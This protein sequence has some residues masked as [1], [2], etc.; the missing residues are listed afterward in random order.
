M[1]RVVMKCPVCGELNYKN[2]N[3]DLYKCSVCNSHFFHLDS[4]EV[5]TLKEAQICLSLYQFDK[6]DQLYQNILINTNDEKIIV[7]ALFGRILAYFGVNYIK[8]FNGN[9][10]LTF[11]NYDPRFKSIKET[12]FYQKLKEN[13]Y[14]ELYEDKINQLDKEY[15][16]I[17]GEL[18]KTPLY[19]VFICTKISL[20]SYDNPTIEGRTEDSA[21]ARMIHDELTRRGLNVFYSDIDLR[22]INY[23]AQIYSALERSKNIVVVASKKEY[24][25]SVWVQ[26]EWQR[27]LH[28]IKQ[29]VKQEK[30]FYLF[31][32]SSKEFELP[33]EISKIQKFYDT[34]ILVN[35]VFEKSQEHKRNQTHS[36]EKELEDGYKFLKQKQYSKA[37]T[38]FRKQLV[39]YNK[40][41]RPWLGVVDVMIANNTPASDKGYQNCFEWIFKLCDD[42]KIR[43]NIANSLHCEKIRFA[44][45]KN[46]SIKSK[47]TVFLMKK[48]CYR[49][50]FYFLNLCKNIK[51]IMGKG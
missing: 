51:K 13:K 25:E 19:D 27:W 35:N 2:V 10:I 20:K 12:S 45:F 8:D 9:L 42:E 4:D 24:L 16:R 36:I 14:Y 30:S 48:N 26:S 5:M 34:L 7:M 22:G 1:E 3:N 44:E 29:G 39:S 37:M 6:A 23:D 21:K 41:Y 33:L 17:N 38:I 46:I 15:E 31:M 18:N 50:A 47:I 32:A 43:N 11:T 28:F 49:T 40:D